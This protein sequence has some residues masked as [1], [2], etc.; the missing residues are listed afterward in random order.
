[1]VIGM[2]NVIWITVIAVVGLQ[3]NVGY[4]GQINMG[5]SAFMGV[6]A[7]AAGL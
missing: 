7:Y 6:G 4:A 2:M 1:M 5:Q 3:I